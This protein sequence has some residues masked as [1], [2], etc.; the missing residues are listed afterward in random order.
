VV[1][2]NNKI[3]QIY[4][5]PFPQKNS[6]KKKRTTVPKELYINHVVLFSHKEE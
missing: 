4:G 3:S 2:E 1:Q 6:K 5:I